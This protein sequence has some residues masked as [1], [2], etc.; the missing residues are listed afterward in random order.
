MNLPANGRVVV[1]DDKA[2]EQALPLLRALAQRGVAS[3]FY[4]GKQG[5]LPEKPLGGIRLIFLDLKLEGM[6]FINDADDLANALKPRLDRIIGPDNGPYILIGWTEHPRYLQKLCASINPPPTLWLDMDKASCIRDGECDVELISKALDK[7]LRG[8]GAFKLLFLW[9][10]LVHESVF[11]TVNDFQ[12]LLGD[13]PDL[14]RAL[15]RLLYGLAKANLEEQIRGKTTAEVI[16]NALLTTNGPFLDRLETNIGKL[17]NYDG[18]G[19]QFFRRAHP[20]EDATAKAKINARLH[21]TKDQATD[22]VP[23]N[24]YD[25]WNKRLREVT[26]EL[27]KKT[28]GHL[29]PAERQ[30]ASG[31]VLETSAFCDHAQNKWTS[32]RLLPGFFIPAQHKKKVRSA[33]TDALF[34]SPAFVFEAP[35]NE[36]FLLVFHFGYLDSCTLRSLKNRKPLFRLRK[37]IVIDIQSQLARHVSRPGIL[38]L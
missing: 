32:H 27:I 35:Y 21:L 7:K 15:K 12:L 23:G 6:E 18:F 14:N 3:R 2:K 13:A 10:Y 26:D 17:D 11:T 24:I 4:T 19:R 28:L 34:I 30:T 31:C 37:D 20:T 1:I 29:Q 25:P 8:L 38:S 5:E 22:S 16:A 33:K 36:P 9:E